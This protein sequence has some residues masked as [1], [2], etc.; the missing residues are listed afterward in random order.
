[1]L[2]LATSAAEGYWIPA[3]AGMTDVRP[4]LAGRM[5]DVQRYPK[6]ALAIILCSAFAGMT[7]VGPLRAGRMM[8]VQWCCIAGIDD[9]LEAA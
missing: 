2:L 5:M 3:F 8:D 9:G 6:T 1:M 4:L 7:D